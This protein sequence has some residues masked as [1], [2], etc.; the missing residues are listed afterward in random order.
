MLL[1]LPCL[2]SLYLFFFVLSGFVCSSVRQ[3]FE[4]VEAILKES[5]GAYCVGDEV[6]MADLFLV[7]QVY[8]ANRFGV[9]MSKFPIISRIN[10]ALSDLPEFKEAHPS[11]QPDAVAP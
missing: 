6:T 11:A 9:D 2:S 1:L 3:G 4:G 8:N 5:A 10:D 7:P